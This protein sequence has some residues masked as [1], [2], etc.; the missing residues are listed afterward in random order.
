MTAAAAMIQPP[1]LTD[2]GEGTSTR[3]C[4]VG[5]RLA[6]REHLIRFAVGPNGEIVADLAEKLPGRGFWVTAE[7]DI[8]ARADAR[9][10][11]RAARASVTVPSNFIAQ[12]EA[13][14]ARRLAD[15]LG[16]AKRAGSLVAGFE[17]TRAALKAGEVKLLIAA[18]DGAADGRAKL[19]ALAP[20]LQEMVALSAAEIGAAL[21]RDAAVHVAV[22]NA[23]LAKVIGRE[24]ARLAGVRGP[25]EQI[26]NQML[27][28]KVD[29]A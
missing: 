17:K 15:Y 21:G 10:F 8:L 25:I 29:Q 20:G 3:R 2:D 12:I 26:C 19:C 7:A 18:Q 23:R 27:S 13:G 6:E 24:G 14:L 5:G 4:I 11:G 22:T 16:I 1:A 28:A 9:V